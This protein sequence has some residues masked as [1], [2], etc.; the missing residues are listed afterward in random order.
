MTTRGFYWNLNI[1]KIEEKIKECE[2]KPQ[3]KEREIELARL[4]NTLY[5]KQNKEQAI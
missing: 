4:E 5:Y 3:S 1:R 2:A